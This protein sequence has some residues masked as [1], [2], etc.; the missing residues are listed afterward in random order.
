MRLRHK[1][2]TWLKKAFANFEKFTEKYVEP[3]IRIVNVIKG[4][5]DNP[6]LDIAVALTHT[7][8]DDNIL[9]WLRNAIDTLEVPLNCNK[10]S[11]IE[12]IKCFIEWLRPLPKP[13]RNAIYLKTASLIAQQADTL[14]ENEVD[15]LVQLEYSE[16]K[17]A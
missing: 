6:N 15:L 4:T 7:K 11:D 10:G 9:Y 1:I 2:K 5:V 17:I 12:K 13:Q 14:S 3:A 16:S 8:V